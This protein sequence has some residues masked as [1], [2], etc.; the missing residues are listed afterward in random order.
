MT[1]T[2][3]LAERKLP[4]KNGY[5]LLLVLHPLVRTVCLAEAVKRGEKTKE[6]KTLGVCGGFMGC[7]AAVITHTH[8]NKQKKYT[9]T[10]GKI[11]NTIRLCLDETWAS[12]GE[13]DLRLPHTVRGEL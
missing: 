6:K 4:F 5:E 2:A 13:L 7:G 3:L 9:S 11:V 8:T 1:C 10:G 12:T